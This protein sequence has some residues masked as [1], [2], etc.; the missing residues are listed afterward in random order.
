MVKNQIKAKLKVFL[1][2]N[3]NKV[4]KSQFPLH[5]GTYPASWTVGSTEITSSRLVSL[6][7][8]WSD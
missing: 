3:Q 1:L 7:E 8:I 4:P 5:S 6:K 2:E